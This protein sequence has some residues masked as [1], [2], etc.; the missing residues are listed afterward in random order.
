PRADATR[1]TEAASDMKS[2]ALVLLGVGVVA[3]QPLDPAQK[4]RAAAL[5]S[6]GSS[7]FA[8]RDYAG[9]LDKYDAA[10]VIYPSPKIHYNRALALEKLHRDAEAADDY[11]LFI[12][13]ATDAPRES[14]D[15][16]R[17]ALAAL[18]RAVG[19]LEIEAS[20]VA[21]ATVDRRAVGTTPVKLHVAVG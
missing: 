18:E 19:K 13:L 20:V 5:V 14:V 15:Q 3:A 16:A 12:T 21:A 9:A 4:D 1:R 17:R 7:R 6:E 2:I 10:F 8:A 11:E